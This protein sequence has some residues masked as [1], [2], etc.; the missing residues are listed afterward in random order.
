M[1][2]LRDEVITTVTQL[3]YIHT[4]FVSHA[5]TIK[6]CT[7]TYDR[8]KLLKGICTFSETSFASNE[9]IFTIRN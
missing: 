3:V 4:D 1:N 6:A 8:H 5:K 9:G 7:L 2:L